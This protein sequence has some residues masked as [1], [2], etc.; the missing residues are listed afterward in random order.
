[1]ESIATA[2]PR[3]DLE[4]CLDL[5]D[6]IDWRTSDHSKDSL[7]SYDDLV[8]WSIRKG[9]LD[10][11]ESKRLHALAKSDRTTAEQ[12]LAQAKDLRE[13][14]Y[15]IF[16]AIA[17]ENEV[18][19]GDVRTLNRFLGKAMAKI[20]V[21][22]TESG[23]KL[24]WCTDDLADKMLYSVAKSAAALLT[25]KHLDR[26]RECANEEEGCGSM[27]L[28]YSKSHSRRWCSMKSCGNKVKV[29]AYYTRH[30]CSPA[31]KR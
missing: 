17:H 13:T 4:L 15:R 24:G 30:N 31:V 22:P 5:T 18:R 10:A 8:D 11:E 19:R 2:I 6:T 25:S 7:Q 16:S 29:R 23:Y 26:V 14:I 27:F 3:P 21:Q 1:M 9:V 12:V 28:D 20:E